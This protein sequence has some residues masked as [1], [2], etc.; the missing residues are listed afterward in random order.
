MKM[1]QTVI[2][3]VISGGIALAQTPQ[4]G[5]V[6]GKPV[7]APNDAETIFAARHGKSATTVEDK[8]EVAALAAQRNCDVIKVQVAHDAREQAKQEFAIAVSPQELEQ[9]N[10]EYIATHDPAA[11]LQ[12][13]RQLFTTLNLAASEVDQGQNPDSVYQS[14]LAPIGVTKNVWEADLVQWREHPESRTHL[15]QTAATFSEWTPQDVKQQMSSATR[16]LL[17]RKK[18]EEAVDAQLAAQDPTFRTYLAEEQ[19]DTV[20]HGAFARSAVVPHTAS[21][22]LDQKRKEFWQARYA[23]QRI[24]INDPNLAQQCQLGANVASA[25]K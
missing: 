16:Q 15:A 1:H 11:E 19:K 17:E 20:R 5:S 24:T 21:T 23:Q 22:Y 2:A 9:A 7:F 6:N 12:K 3:F 13:Q 14:L 10:S 18:L 4:I 25:K 8:Q